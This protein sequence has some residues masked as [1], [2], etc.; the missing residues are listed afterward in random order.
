MNFPKPIVLFVDEADSLQDENS[1]ALLRQ[2]RSGFESRPDHFPQGIALVGLRDV[3]DYKIGLRPDSASPGTGSPF[4][5]K[6]KSLFMG[7]F[8]EQEVNA[9]MDLHQEASG[10]QFSHE[11]RGEI[12]RLT[13][14]QPWLTNALLNEIVAGAG[15]QKPDLGGDVRE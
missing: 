1:L 8:G 13:Q 3:R 14:G 7:G 15:W 4:N 10:Q 11:V 12:Y 9:L 5:I 6:T 2:L